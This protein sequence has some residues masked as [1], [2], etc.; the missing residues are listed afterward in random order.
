LPKKGIVPATIAVFTKNSERGIDL[1][2]KPEA[3]SVVKRD[4]IHLNSL[5]ISSSIRNNKVKSFEK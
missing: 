3:L 2:I 5:I 1:P 4:P